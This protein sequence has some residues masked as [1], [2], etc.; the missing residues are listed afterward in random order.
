[1]SDVKIPEDRYRPI[2]LTIDDRIHPPLPIVQLPLSERFRIIPTRSILL[3]ID[4]GEM[5]PEV[6]EAA[7]AELA[8]RGVPPPI[9]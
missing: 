1:M 3:Y 2:I 5:T 8:R 7:L 9:A 4:M 6:K